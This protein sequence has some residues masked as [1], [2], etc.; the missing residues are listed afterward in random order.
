[1][2]ERSGCTFFIYCTIYIMTN[3]EEKMARRA[4]SQ[5]ALHH[6]DIEVEF[7]RYLNEPITETDFEGYTITYDEVRTLYSFS[8][9][10]GFM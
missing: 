1:M 9:I 8:P 2:N 6:V 10:T 5:E 7:V 4:E 3:F